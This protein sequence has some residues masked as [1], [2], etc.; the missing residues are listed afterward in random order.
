[1]K[2]RSSVAG[3]KLF[4]ARKTRRLRAPLNL[5]QVC[6]TTSTPRAAAKIILRSARGCDGDA[7]L[8]RHRY[9]HLYPPEEARRGVSKVWK[10]T[11]RRGRN[12]S[13][14]LR[15]ATLR[16]RQECSPRRGARAIERARRSAACPASCEG[17]GPCL[18]RNSRRARI[19]WRN[20]WQPRSV[21]RGA[22]TR[23]RTDAGY[24]Q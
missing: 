24:E 8:A 20:D 1:M 15:R 7:I 18:Q 12:F 21:D 2:W 11:S 10:T 17:R 9:F 5:S 6:L 19:A 16:R 14:Y 4:C 23:S 3:R 22:R 13:H